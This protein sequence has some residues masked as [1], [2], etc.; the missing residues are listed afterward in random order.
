MLDAGHQGYEQLRSPLQLQGEYQLPQHA[1]GTRHGNPSV[2][3][4]DEGAGKDLMEA[5][6]L[7]QR[8]ALPLQM[9][10]KSVHPYICDCRTKEV[11]YTL[12]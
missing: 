4:P 9:S 12:N 2:R 1:L 6:S 5:A 11:G 10:P 3:T 8:P 7:G